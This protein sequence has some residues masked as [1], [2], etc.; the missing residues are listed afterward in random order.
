MLSAL[1]LAKKCRGQTGINLHLFY[2]L[3]LQYQID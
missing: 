3:K 2:K 1:F